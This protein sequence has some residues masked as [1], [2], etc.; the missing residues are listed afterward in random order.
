VAQVVVAVAD[1][2]VMGQVQL[3]CSQLEVPAT[4]LEGRAAANSL[5]SFSLPSSASW[6]LILRLGQQV[7]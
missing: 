7:R 2:Q 4:S 5:R 6:V 3:L 1:R